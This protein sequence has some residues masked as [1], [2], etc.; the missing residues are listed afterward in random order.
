M[1]SLLIY[2]ILGAIVTVVLIIIAI[3]V[4]LNSIDSEKKSNDN[5]NNNYLPPINTPEQYQNNQQMQTGQ[6]YVPPQNTVSTFNNNQQGQYNYNS[7]QNYIPPVNNYYNTTYNNNQYFPYQAVNLL[8]NKEYNFFRALK[9]IAQRNDLN[10][11]MKI[12]LADLVKVKDSVPKSDFYKY[13]NKISSKHIDFAIID[14]T[15]VV[16]LI[17]LDDSTHNRISRIERDNF[18]NEIVIR[19]GYKIIRTYGDIQ[20]IEYEISQYIKSKS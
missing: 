15:K 7:P 12:R 1:D 19:C 10:V 14:E 4:I 16:I 3:I 18:V 2:L 20:Q 6:N 11:L 8:T 13:F 9:I 17:E 5:N